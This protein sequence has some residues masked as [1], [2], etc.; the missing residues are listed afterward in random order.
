MAIKPEPSNDRLFNDFDSYLFHEGSNYEAYRKLGAHL[1]VENGVS[2]VRFAV[3]APHAR[4]VSVL[5]DGNGWTV[6][7]DAMEPSQWGVWET[8]IP[9]MPEGSLYQ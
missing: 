7:A 3:W 2:G 8:F 9:G 5:S 6:G 1:R 4:S